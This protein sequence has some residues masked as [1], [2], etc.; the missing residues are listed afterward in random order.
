MSSFLGGWP[1][2][3]EEHCHINLPRDSIPYVDLKDGPT[4]FMERNLQTKIIRL[5]SNFYAASLKGPVDD[6]IIAEHNL[7]LY[8][9]VIQCLPPVFKL[10]DADTSCYPSWLRFGIRFDRYVEYAT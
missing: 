9:E 6:G 5:V 1:L 4:P 10:F 2:I 8:E 7:L 3:P